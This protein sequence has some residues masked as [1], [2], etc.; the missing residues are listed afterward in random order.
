MIRNIVF[1]IFCWEAQNKRATILRTQAD[2]IKCALEQGRAYGRPKVV[3]PNNF[4]DI[5]IKWKNGEITG[6]KAIELT[7]LK[8]NKF[9]D[10]V[11]I[12]E[13]KELKNGK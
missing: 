13:R 10:F 4:E 6:T 2:G 5:Y 7:G 9:Y 12:Y 3:M 8:R 1:E 11:K